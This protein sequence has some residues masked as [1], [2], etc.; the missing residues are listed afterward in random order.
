MSVLWAHT[1][2][3]GVNLEYINKPITF[4]TH[5]LAILRVQNGLK[6]KEEVAMFVHLEQSFAWC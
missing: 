3:D 2:Y 1:D 5:L 4:L 6:F